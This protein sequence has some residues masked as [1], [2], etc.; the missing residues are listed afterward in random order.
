MKMSACD[1]NQLFI[2]CIPV[3]HQQRRCLV[4]R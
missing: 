3:D 4:I 2:A 1:L